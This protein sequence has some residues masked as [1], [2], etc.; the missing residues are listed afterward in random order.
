M[1]THNTFELPQLTQNAARTRTAIYS[2]ATSAVVPIGGMQWRFALTAAC[3]AKVWKFRA[4]GKWGNDDVILMLDHSIVQQ[5]I[6]AAL[7]NMDFSI[8]PAEIITAATETVLEE[9]LDALEQVSGLPLT[10]SSILLEEDT[11]DCTPEMLPFTLTYIPSAHSGENDEAEYGGAPRF[12]TDEDS[13]TL[14]YADTEASFTTEQ[15]D[16]F[17]TDDEDTSGQDWNDAQSRYHGTANGAAAVPVHS[18][19]K[20][21]QGIPSVIHGA[22]YV[23]DAEFS[24][25]SERTLALNFP[26]FPQ[27]GFA[28]GGTEDFTEEFAETSAKDSEPHSPLRTPAW[29]L[30]HDP[31]EW[32]APARQQLFTPSESLEMLLKL[33]HQY[34]V[35]HPEGYISTERV[36]PLPL[37]I[38][39]EIGEVRLPLREL[40]DVDPQDILLL[41]SFYPSSTEP[42]DPM[43]VLLRI[44][45]GPVLQGTRTGT[46]I[47]IQEHSMSTDPATAHD[48]A[49]HAS[50]AHSHEDGFAKPVVSHADLSSIE[51]PVRLEIDTL[52]M[53]I[54]QLSALSAGCLLETTRTTD[55]AVTLSVNGKAIGTGELVDVAGKIG[56]R[57]LT[58]GMNGANSP[59]K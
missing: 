38:P 20:L 17:F 52:T 51:L 11:A 42:A 21:P 47:T 16:S 54:E 1:D 29:S 22:L 30:T 2:G 25:D 37:R 18:E 19:H 46:T 9:A 34:G 40:F 48:A 36:N 31:P 4:Y 12:G 43:S 23:T 3:A 53:S 13:E 39:V 44:P 15:D 14:S 59:Q 32:L 28:E 56:V 50:S 55:A 41:D 57:V 5:W 6:T 8:L 10:V 45:N 33:L 7:G 26:V 49:R 24:E 58:F 27:Q 35:P